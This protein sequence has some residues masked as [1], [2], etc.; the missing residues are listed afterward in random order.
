MTTKEA[1]GDFLNTAPEDENKTLLLLWRSVL[2]RAVYDLHVGR[3]GKEAIRDRESA[4]E[5]FNSEEGEECIGSF[6]FVCS[7]LEFDRFRLLSRLQ[8]L[9]YLD[10]SAKV[11][12][13]GRKVRVVKIY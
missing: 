10:G 9:G 6:A 12:G 1:E 7:T 5:W 13:R 11:C 8:E 4:L 2:L 3:G